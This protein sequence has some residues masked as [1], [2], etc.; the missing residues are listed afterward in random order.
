MQREEQRNKQQ[1]GCI[2][3]ER[4]SPVSSALSISCLEENVEAE[5]QQLNTETEEQ[6]TDKLL[7]KDHNE[8]VEDNVRQRKG[9]NRKEGECSLFETGIFKCSF[10]Q[11]KLSY[12]TNKHFCE[13]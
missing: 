13:N 5:T 11:I 3:P 4:N 8:S 12:Y 9:S 2:E 6:E 1:N 7:K 10:H